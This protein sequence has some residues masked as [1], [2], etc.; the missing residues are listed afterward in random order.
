[1]KDAE[2][3]IKTIK[4][5]AGEQE[6]IRG[7]ILIGSYVQKNKVDPVSDIDLCFF[8]TEPEKYH[9][10]DAWLQ[11]FAPVWL[12]LF[13]EQN[14]TFV[15]NTIFDPGILAE[16]YIYPIEALQDITDH[17]PPNFNPGYQILLDKD[18]R[19]RKLPKASGKIQ[20]PE[21][22]N[23]ETFQTTIKLFWFNALQVAKYLWRGELWRAKHYDWTT[24]QLL[25]KLLGWHALMCRRQA[26]FT[27]Y[28]GKNF[29][30]WISPEIYTDV[31]TAFGR[32]Y[33]ADSW[34]ALEITIRLFSRF[35]KEVAE[36][37]G[38]SDMQEIENKILPM[39]EDMKF[40]R[41]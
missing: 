37:L 19:L 33:P 16:F 12:S 32:F 15:W 5:W 41:I 30:S 2:R 29:Q 13:Q 26:N 3:L 36:A 11:N 8:T 14:T 39:I 22:P 24:K 40:N 35:S 6:D 7:V 17:L 38:A 1:M 34:R 9:V 10:Q 18:K 28:E 20:P 23:V 4:Q 27:F 21:I 31:M 25:L